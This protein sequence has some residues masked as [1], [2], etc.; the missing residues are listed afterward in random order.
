MQQY[1]NILKFWFGR[2]EQTIAPTENRSRIWFSDDADVDE[3]I[4]AEFAYDL[5]KADQG[6]YD[7]WLLKPRGQLAM[8][9]LFDQFAR[10]MFRGT[11]RA[12]QYDNKALDIVLRGLEHDSDHEL[13]LIERV[14]YYFPLLHSEELY[15]QEQSLR[16]YALVDSLAFDE[17]HVIYGSFLKFAHHHHGVITRYGRFPQ[18]NPILDR[19]STAE[20]LAFLQSL[21]R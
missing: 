4:R 8:I 21:E 12:F 15:H 16:C 13:S 17:T 6:H 3:M 19:P 14:F 18:R 9:L 20:E 7:D 2:V 5:E 1:D 11:P 10:H